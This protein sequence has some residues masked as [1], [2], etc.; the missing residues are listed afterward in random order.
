MAGLKFFSQ[1]N[2]HGQDAYGVNGNKQWN[3]TKPEI[4]DWMSTQWA[5]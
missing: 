3:E 1:H 2:K 4:S 5:K